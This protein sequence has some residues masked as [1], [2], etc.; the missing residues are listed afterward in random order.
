MSFLA[1]ALTPV[2]YVFSRLSGTRYLTAE[3]MRARGAKVGENVYIG[4]NRIDY[5]HMFL[6]EIGSNVILSNCRI[7]TH[8][9]ST[10][11]ALGYSKVGRVIIGDDVFIGAEVIILPGVRIGNKCV[12]GAGAVVTKDIPDNSVA[13]GNPARVVGTYDDYMAKCQAEIDECRKKGLV[14]ET[15]YS[16]KTP[17]EFQKMKD[18]LMGGGIGYDI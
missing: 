15:H 13:V 1:K 3:Q 18:D 4:T 6:I 17:A 7:L 8:D 9:A 12:V 11:R 16:Q 14:Y 10:K 2:K 5:G